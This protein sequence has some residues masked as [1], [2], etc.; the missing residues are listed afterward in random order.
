MK[1]KS[2]HRRAL[3]GRVAP[4]V[5]VRESYNLLDVFL[6]LWPATYLVYWIGPVIDVVRA[7]LDFTMENKFEIIWVSI[8]A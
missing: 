5:A 3:A 4:L 6:E 1:R 7:N 8:M 2:I